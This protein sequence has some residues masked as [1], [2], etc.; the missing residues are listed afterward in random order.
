MANPH[1]RFFAPLSHARTTLASSF[2]HSH[3]N[4]HCNACMDDTCVCGHCLRVCRCAVC[5]GLCI[6][7]LEPHISA[8]RFFFCS[9]CC[10]CC[11]TYD[12][13]IIPSLKLS[14]FIPCDS[15]GSTAVAHQAFF[16]F[17]AATDGASVSACVRVLFPMGT[18]TSSHQERCKDAANGAGQCKTHTYLL[19]ISKATVHV[20]NNRSGTTLSL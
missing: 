8:F 12:V 2:P 4:G 13:C 5:A 20:Y 19:G 17:V 9:A 16:P 14:S 6:F 3:S 1:F 10:C 11:C 7:V 18:N 15:H